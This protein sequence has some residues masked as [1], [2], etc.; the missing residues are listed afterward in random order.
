V[1]TLS[2][3]SLVDFLKGNF[4]GSRMAVA[5]TGAVSADALVRAF[6]RVRTS[7]FKCTC[8]LREGRG[9][10]ARKEG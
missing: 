7:Q 6:V 8:L 3:S 1:S 5:G 10:G 2:K 9:D 4:T